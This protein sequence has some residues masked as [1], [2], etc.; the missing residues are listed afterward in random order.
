MIYYLIY[1]GSSFIF[2][3]LEKYIFNL[4]II[5]K[6]FKKYFFLIQTILLAVCFLANITVFS[7]HLFDDYNR[8]SSTE[9]SV[10]LIYM[11]IHFISNS[12]YYFQYQTLK[13][14]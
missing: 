6:N 7:I 4:K 12:V 10:C 1:L 2:L 8:I 9:V 5:S 3:S 13:N 14:E 11:H